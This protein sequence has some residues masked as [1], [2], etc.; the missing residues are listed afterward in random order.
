MERVFWV[1]CPACSGKFY[2]NYDELRHAAIK[3]LCPFC[4]NRFLPD[5]AE[6]LDER[7]DPRDA[8]VASDSG[9]H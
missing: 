7:W 3:L 4:H 2:C 1:A 5:E 9:Q 8:P 6:A